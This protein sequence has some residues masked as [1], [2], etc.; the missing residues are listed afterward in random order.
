ML[1]FICQTQL[2]NMANVS[3][4]LLDHTLNDVT[5]II[6]CAYHI[7]LSDGFISYSNA[8]IEKECL[9]KS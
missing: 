3:S 1:R 2:Y 7:D 5:L 4:A 9:P 6:P 8:P